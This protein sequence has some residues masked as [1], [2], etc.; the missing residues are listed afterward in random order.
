[1]YIH[2]RIHYIQATHLGM[3]REILDILVFF[4]LH[5]DM[6]Y[7]MALHYP[8]WYTSYAQ[9]SMNAIYT[10]LLSLWWLFCAIW[11]SCTVDLDVLVVIRLYSSFIYTVMCTNQCDPL[12]SCIYCLVL[13]VLLWSFVLLALKFK[14]GEFFSFSAYHHL[15]PKCIAVLQSC[16]FWFCVITSFPESSSEL[17]II[18]GK[19]N[20]WILF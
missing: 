17:F 16:L 15:L 12:T 18:K 7:I 8:F 13:K 6:H 11:N 9:S 1:M 10:E 14:E 2:R 19:L 3:H 5:R 4:D 20:W